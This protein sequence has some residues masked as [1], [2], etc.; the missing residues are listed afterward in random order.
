MLADNVAPITTVMSAPRLFTSA[1]TIGRTITNTPQFE[2]VMN[3]TKAM[4]VK[5]IAGKSSGVGIGSMVVTT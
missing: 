2:P 5:I 1:V 3:D 4:D